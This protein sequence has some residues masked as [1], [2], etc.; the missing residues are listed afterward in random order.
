MLRL[1]RDQAE[2][3]E[4]DGDEEEDENMSDSQGEQGIPVRVQLTPRASR[5]KA[6]QPSIQ[7]QTAQG[8]MGEQEA[9]IREQEM[10]LKELKALLKQQTPITSANRPFV[11]LAG[12]D[13]QAT[14]RTK[15]WSTLKTEP[16]T[17]GPTR[18]RS[19]T[20]DKKDIPSDIIIDEV[21]TE[22]D[23]W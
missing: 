6:H 21:G 10:E 12:A 11:S 19:R 22:E 15:A 4:E 3:D 7:V 2:S 8:Q 18:E 14:G 9:K 5:H 17:R 13:G 23:G 1:F 20:P 16:E